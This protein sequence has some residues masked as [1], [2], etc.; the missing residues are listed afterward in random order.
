MY[1]LRT[2]SYI[3]CYSIVT[4]VVKIMREVGEPG[5]VVPNVDRVTTME[6]VFSV[7]TNQNHLYLPSTFHRD[8]TTLQ[9][10]NSHGGCTTITKTRKFDRIHGNGQQSC[11]LASANDKMA[12]NQPPSSRTSSKHPRSWQTIQTINICTRL[13]TEVKNRFQVLC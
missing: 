9:S 5:E 12:Q 7:S 4:C 10:F 6:G 3:L 8:L 2:W 11:R 1:L 13:N